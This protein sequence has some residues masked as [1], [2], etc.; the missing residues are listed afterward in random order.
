MAN[1]AFKEV[2]AKKIV[3][4]REVSN[5]YSVGLAKFYADAFKK[6]TGDPS[7][8]LAELE[9]QHQR[10]GLHRPAHHREV[11]EAGRHLRAGQLHRERAHHQAGARARHHGAIPRRR[12][13]G[14]ARVRGRRQAGGRGRGPLHLLRHR[15]AHHPDQQGVPG[16]LPEEVPEGPGG[17][18]RARLRRLPGGARGHREGAEPG[19][20][21]DQGRARRD[22]GLP[23]RGRPH[24][25]R[26]GP[27]R[28]EERR[29]QGGEGREV[30][31]PDHRPTL[32]AAPSPA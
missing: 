32:C 10:P 1:Y 17:G 31:L 28:H 25:L 18:D 20:P 19:R 9:L 8:I 11:D 24:H 23:G 12:H 15:G 29:H 5:D 22:Q 7:A 2:K 4:I 16:R 27:Q 21:E 6:L 26:R 3:I 13:L 30:R 14:G